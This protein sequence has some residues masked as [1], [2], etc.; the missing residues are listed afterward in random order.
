MD[1]RFPIEDQIDMLG[2]ALKGRV[3]TRRDAEFDALHKAGAVIG[4]NL[5]PAA[6]IRVANAA[7]VAAVLNFAQA[8]DLPIAVRSGGHSPWSNVGGG[9]LIDLREL[10]GIEIDAAART[11]WVGTGLTAGEVTLAVEQHG[12]IVGFGDSASVGLGGLVTGGGIGYLVRKHG[13]SIDSLLAVEIVTAHGG[14]VVADAASHPDLFW[15]VRGGG[16]NFGIVTRMKFRLH[17]LPQFTGGPLVLPATPETLAGF[18]AASAA[19][20]EELSTIGLVMPCPP[21]PMLPADMHGKT[22]LI[23]MLAY[24][25]APDAAQA[26][27]A[28][29]RRLATPIA[30]LVR[31]GPYSS[32]YLP[33]PP[34]KFAS[35]IRS[36]F[37]EK[38]GIEEARTMLDQLARVDSP[39]KM[40]QIRTL[41]GAASRV[42]ADATAFA[43]RDARFLVVFLAM[44][45]PDAPRDRYEQWATEAL[46]AIQPGDH[47]AYVNFLAN[48][49]AAGLSAAYPA[50][51]WE[52]LRRVKRMYDPEN[53][54]RLNQNIPPAA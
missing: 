16:G 22:V 53:L 38:F 36:R 54:F 28:P 34:V 17:A 27:L 25:G 18:A 44:F 32:M 19:A 7:D 12:L 11:A 51:T 9:L 35:S 21:L 23:G 1:K 39:M 13:L 15:A 14:V 29:F 37:V 45:G 41:G 26:A 49:G 6:I 8:T 43:H 30:D 48:E 40:G 24:A 20:P 2:Y 5:T 3:V 50:A 46:A 31:P 4:F 52:K 33:E 10:N 47:G 42:A